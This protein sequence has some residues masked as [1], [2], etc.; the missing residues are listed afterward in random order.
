MPLA[1]PKLSL[2]TYGPSDEE[3]KAAKKVLKSCDEKALRS[4][5]GSM[6]AFIS[7]HASDNPGVLLSRGDA[8][9]E[10]LC[11][12]ICH[13]LK[14]KTTTKQT[15]NVEESSHKEEKVAEKVWWSREQIDR[16]LG[17]IKSKAWRSSGKLATRPDRITGST[18]PDLIEFAIPIDYERMTDEEL[19]KFRVEALGEAGEGH[20]QMIEGM[21]KEEYDKPTLVKAEPL[22]QEAKDMAA[23]TEFLASAPE[24]LHKYHALE[25]H[26][27]QLLAGL[28]KKPYTDLLQV[29]VKR[30]QTRIGG[31][32]KIL[33]KA[34]TTKLEFSEWPKLTKAMAVIMQQ[35]VA[36]SEHGKRFGVEMGKQTKK[37]KTT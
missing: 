35:D 17:E 9:K 31:I 10:F 18:E 22:T 32:I 5:M 4:K 14:S 36:M 29:E 27:K 7:K 3:L 21:H 2:E 16:E 15:S 26:T 19:D 6:S 11:K 1:L 23:F 33:S 28:Q 30:H 12:F 34:V 8:R 13:Q 25:I 20:L 24:H 37:R